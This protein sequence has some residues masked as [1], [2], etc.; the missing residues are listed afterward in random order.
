MKKFSITDF[1]KLDLPLLDKFAILNRMVLP[2][3]LV[4]WVI[5]KIWG[6]NIPEKYNEYATTYQIT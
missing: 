2:Q 6:N 5:V 1:L 4:E 3:K